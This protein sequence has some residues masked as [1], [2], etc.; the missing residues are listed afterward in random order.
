MKQ[1]IKKFVNENH[2]QLMIGFFVMIGV[3][4]TFFWFGITTYL[5]YKDNIEID[6][7]CTYRTQDNQ[8]KLCCIYCL[9]EFEQKNFMFNPIDYSCSCNGIKK[10]TIGIE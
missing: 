10:V 6:N 1:K 8:T 4:L 7:Q 5:D 3:V 9:K 2:Y